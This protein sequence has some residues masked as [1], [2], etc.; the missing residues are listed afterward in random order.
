M[1]GRRDDLSCHRVPH[2]AHVAV[3]VGVPQLPVPPAGLVQLHLWRGEHIP[4]L[5]VLTVL[6][7]RAQLDAP[8]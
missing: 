8:L 6:V 4:T 2:E 3:V 1:R 5:Q 7:G